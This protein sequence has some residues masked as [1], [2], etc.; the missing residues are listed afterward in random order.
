[1]FTHIHIY[2]QTY[3]PHSYV[4]TYVSVY[5]YIHIHISILSILEFFPIF[6]PYPTVK[7]LLRTY[8]HKYMYVYIYRHM[9]ILNLY[10][11]QCTWYFLS[12]I[13]PFYFISKNAG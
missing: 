4:H 6:S 12:Y 9:Y 2:T 13:I 10:Y 5:I 1:M 7:H 11:V 8:M 3:I